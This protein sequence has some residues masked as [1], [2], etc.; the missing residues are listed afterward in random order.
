MTKQEFITIFTEKLR[1]QITKNPDQYVD[2]VETAP[3]LADKMINR[4]LVQGARTVSLGPALK[5]AL[6]ACKRPATYTGLEN[7]LRDI[8]EAS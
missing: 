5:A 2:T 3:A 4:L 6:R 8:K 7:L 1:E